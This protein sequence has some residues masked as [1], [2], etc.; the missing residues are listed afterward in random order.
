MAALNLLWSGLEIGKS[1]GFAPSFV[2]GGTLEESPIAK[3]LFKLEPRH[4]AKFRKFRLKNVEK[5]ASGKKLK[6]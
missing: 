3:V 1:L 4:V 5:S 6:H 2:L